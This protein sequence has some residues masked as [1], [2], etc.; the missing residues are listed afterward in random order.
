MDFE[1]I[2]NLLAEAKASIDEFQ[3]NGVEDTR[4]EAHE[5][6]VQLARALEKPRDA[7]LKLS[8]SPTVF[9]AVKVAHDMSVFPILNKS[10]V[11]VSVEE[12][13]AAKPADPLLVERIMRLLVANGF[14]E[15]PEPCKYL[16]T[17]LSEEMTQRTS[18]GV[19]ESLFLEFLPSIQ[20]T[21]EYLQS[22]GYRNPEDPMY[23]PLQYANNIKKDGFAWLCKDPA[24][25]SRFNSFMEG[26]RA[27]RAFWGD[28]F[29]VRDVILNAPTLSADRPLLVDIGGG[30]GHDLLEFKTRFPDAQGKLVL[31]DLPSVIDEVRQAND[32]EGAGIETVKYDFFA[33][34]Q[35]VHGARVYYFKYVLH[36]WS[37]EKAHIIFDHLKKAMVP[38]YSKV[39]IEEYI[40]PD[41]N[42]RAVNGMTDMAVMVFCAG[43]E[44]TR[45]R[46]LNL[47]ES[48]GLR[49]NKFW[50]RGGD[51]LGIIEAEVPEDP[52]QRKNI[53]IQLAKP[54]G[55]QGRDSEAVLE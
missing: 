30:R 19:V 48:V 23:A 52:N 21:P 31:E 37:D 33:D 9:M 13:A 20:K 36:D 38:G 15:E 41:R 8:F 24:A 18:I 47:L 55:T 14:A 10:A 16:P 32:L 42:A 3:T 5:K 12:L 50:T 34:V 26:Q 22:T 29:P 40:L 2:N 27:N 28:W 39:L 1:L 53:E 45:Q 44:R 11:P 43:L 54:A 51:A 46:W 35:P 4:I 7:I 25:L 17:P 49:V 6:V